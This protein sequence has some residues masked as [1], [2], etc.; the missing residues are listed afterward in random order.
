LRLPEIGD[1]FST[2]HG[3][4]GVVGLIAD[5]EDIPFT[6]RGVKPDLMFNPQGIPSRMTIGYLIE[7]LAGK[8]AS[9]N[10]K[11]ID[12]TPFA[13]QTAEELEEQLR[14]MGFSYDGKESMYNGITGKKMDVKIYIGN[15][16]YL[17]LKHMVG[18]KLHARA[19]GKVA[20]LTRQP[21]EGRARGGGLRLGEMEQQALAGHGASLLL[22]ERY[23][24]D[25]T[26][27]W[28]CKE[29]GNMTYEDTLRNKIGCDICGSNESEAIEVSYAF[30][31]L[32]DELLGLGIHTSFELKEKYAR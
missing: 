28:I 3:Q 10:G 22:K 13:G 32:V 26:V 11:I 6:G 1:K 12:G 23:D 25:K 2:P 18:N 8:V 19:S 31:L 24:S 29:C 30:K 20:L 16:Y 27:I 7:L 17:K 4:K 14:E 9:T 21:I 5:A 15:M